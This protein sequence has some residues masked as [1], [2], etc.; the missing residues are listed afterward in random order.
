LEKEKFISKLNIKDYSNELEK[1]LV[2]KTFSED[3][4]NLLLSIIYK[5]EN[6]Y[7]D[8]KTAN[9]DVKSK[10]EV[11]EEILKIIKKDCDTIEII[12]DKKNEVMQEEKKIVSYLNAKK[13]LYSLYELQEKKFKVLKSYEL[14][15]KVLEETL[16]QGYSI[17]NSEIIRDFDGWSWNILVNEI[18]NIKANLIYKILKILVGESFLIEW[19]NDTTNKDYIQELLQKLDKNYNTELSE[20]VFKIICQICILN[21]VINDGRKKE[22]FLKVQEELQQEFDRMQDKDKYLKNISDL[23]KE[24]SA[25]IKNIDETINNDRALKKEFIARNELLDMEHRIFS[26]SDFV[27]VLLEEREALI[28]KINIYT[29]KMDPL[30]FI[31]TKTELETKLNFIKELDLKKADNKVYNTKVK[32]LLNITNKALEIQINNAEEQERIKDLIYKIRYYRLIYIDKTKQIKDII[33]LNKLQEKVITK[34][35]K[36]KL[37]N[38]FSLNIKENYEVV[39][40]IFE[41]DI[42]ELSKI[43]FKL[44]KKDE[45][46]ILEIYDENNLYKT[47]ELSEIKELNVKLNKKYKVII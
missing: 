36:L 6:S 39:K 23:K 46:Q 20:K 43:Q 28:Q 8:Y 31:K 42:I 33:S 5:I 44:I 21:I 13:I 45:K 24:V 47:I 18:E 17:A 41:T 16:N 26:L 2:K 10:R 14:I 32:E 7:N 29:N 30:K 34:A 25:E 15:D 12:K 19:K 4:K 9:V 40:N 22:I 35:C 11:F 37:I 38:I 27:D 1:I 3:A